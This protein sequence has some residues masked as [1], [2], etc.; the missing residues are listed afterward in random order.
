PTQR[1]QLWRSDD[2]GD[3][4]Q[5]VSYD[6]Q[7]QGRA[8]YY[9]RCA[10]SPD[11][12][13]EIYFMSAAFSRSLDG[14]RTLTNTPT[15]PGGDNHDL[16]IDPNN[17]DRLA[18]ANDGGFS[19]SVNRGR[20]W[21]RVQLPIA[22]LYHVTVDNQIPYFVYGNKQDGSSY[23]G[24]SNSLSGGR[25]GGGEGETPAE[26]TA[27]R[28]PPGGPLSGGAWR[29]VTGGE[30]GFATPD[31][32]DPNIIWSTA[33]GSGSVGGI[34]TLFDERNHQARHV[35]IWPEQTNGS[36]AAD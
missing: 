10:A 5:L 4:W 3:N 2:L 17:S 28:G 22:Q 24:P 32:V 7:L 12:E 36:P 15:A 31:P 6:R 16:W 30:S 21:N 9:T 33:S 20:T 35:E 8:A 1:G 34:V 11:N 25:G 26:E 14:G 18:V 27:G 29:P 19:I 23:R 13:N